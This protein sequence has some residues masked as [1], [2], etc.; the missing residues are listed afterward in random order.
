MNVRLSK[1][2]LSLGLLMI[3]MV[4]LP[5]SLQAQQQLH[6]QVTNSSGQPISGVSIVVKGASPQIGTSTDNRGRFT[7]EVPD[8]SILRFS[9]VGY[10]T[11]ERAVDGQDEIQVSLVQSEAALDEVVVVGYGTQKKVTLTGAV[12]GVK[13]TEMRA[14]K[15]ENPQNM[16]AG[17]IAGVRVWQQS[18]EPG[19]YRANF[20]IRGMGAPLV[21]IDGVPRSIEDFQRLNPNDIEDISVL[22]DASASIYGVRSANGVMLVTTRK[23]REG[24]VSVGYNGSFTFQRPSNMPFLAD[25]FEAMT[26]YNEKSMN[27]I[28][29]GNLIYTEAD[30]EAFRDGSRRSSDWTSLIFSDVSPQTSHDLSISGGSAKTQYYIGAGYASQEGFFK[31]GD[32]NYNKVNLRSN[33]TTE[34]IDGLK[35]DINLAGMADQQNNPYSSSVDIIRNYWRQGMLF[36][37]YADPEETMLNYEGL[38]LEQNT[39]AMIDSD[40]SGYRKYKKKTFH[41]S[42]SPIYDSRTLSESLQGFTAKALIA[43]DYRT[44]NNSI[45]RKEYAQYAFDPITDSYLQRNYE[46]SSPNRLR[47]EFYEKQQILR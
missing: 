34:I 33:I 41:T 27:N 2:A 40:I 19:A 1:M 46:L 11:L 39:V 16:L 15:N 44:D 26:L 42:A 28:N 9:F 43:Y 38:D 29:G 3:W 5:L 24:A 21:I 7:L 13:G 10:E 36:P 4:S 18:A 25:A 23:G 6:G 20:D 22:K 17:R 14:T 35:F 31:T 32:L 12:S 8:E 47:R 37:A 30:F 45:F